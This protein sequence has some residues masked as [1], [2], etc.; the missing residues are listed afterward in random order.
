M[1]V[2]VTGP[3]FLGLA[4][5]NLVAWHD[6]SVRALGWRPFTTDAWWFCP[7]PAPNI[8]HCAISRRPARDRS[9]R[10]AIV[11]EL[12]EHLHRPDSVHTSVCD[13]WNELALGRIGLDQRTISP[14][15]ARVAAPLPASP[16]ASLA[17]SPTAFGRELHIEEVRTAGDLAV[18]ERTVVAGFGARFPLAPFDIHD[19]AILADPA[20]HVFL[21]TAVGEEDERE[22]DDKD[23]DERR[24][25]E[26]VAVSMAY[27]DG[28]LLGIYG[29]ATVPAARRHGFATAMTRA[30]LAVDLAS[31]AVLQPSHAAEPLYRQLG[32]GA[33]GEFSHWT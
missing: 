15:F 18:F 29:V 24:P 31:P 32:F 6:S 16:A 11:K 5:A 26:A 3:A 23:D 21:G 7:T 28:T 10:T 8:Y 13:S 25:R 19:P 30:A 1:T 22:D 20:M 4:A 9:D 2:D 33:V 14:W 12:D 27:A 17:A